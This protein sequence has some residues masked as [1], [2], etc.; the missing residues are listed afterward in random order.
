MFP[1]IRRATGVCLFF[2]LYTIILDSDAASFILSSTFLLFDYQGHAS[3]ELS[4]RFPISHSLDSV[5][6]WAEEE[7]FAIRSVSCSDKIYSRYLKLR[8][9]SF[10][11]LLGQVPSLS[12]SRTR[13]FSLASIILQVKTAVPNLTRC[14]NERCQVQILHQGDKKGSFY[15]FLYDGDNNKTRS[16]GL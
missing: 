1:R 6:S 13:S 15:F 16:N 9:V 3:K 14:N 5:Q 11:R 4:N 10:S 12:P 8:S 7:G 2:S